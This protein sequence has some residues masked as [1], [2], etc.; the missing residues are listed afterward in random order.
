M[1]RHVASRF[2]RRPSSE[3]IGV[4]ESDFARPQRQDFDA[5]S[6]D[7]ESLHERV[8]GRTSRSDSSELE[9]STAASF[10]TDVVLPTTI[11]ATTSHALL[12]RRPAAAD[13]IDRVIRLALDPGQRFAGRRHDRRCGFDGARHFDR[14]GDR[15]LAEP[16][17]RDRDRPNAAARPSPRPSS[18]SSFRALARALAATPAPRR[19]AVCTRHAVDSRSGRARRGAIDPPTRRE[20]AR[21]HC[22]ELR[23]S[24]TTVS[25]RAPGTASTK[26][27]TCERSVAG[28]SLTRLGGFSGGIRVEVRTL[29]AMGGSPKRRL[30]RP[31]RIP[32]KRGARL[33][34]TRRPDST[35]CPP[36]NDVEC[37][38]RGAA[39]RICKVRFPASDSHL[40]IL[41]ARTVGSARRRSTQASLQAGRNSAHL[42]SHR[43]PL[44]ISVARTPASR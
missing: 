12:R 15:E 28:G 7:V 27:S 32:A 22:R 23:P 34:R 2:V 38:R 41:R 43:A 18:Y 10:D 35:S 24:A 9:C 1:S 33:A 39:T 17:E 14:N 3:P 21:G 16:L 4:R 37:S 40:A 13:S 44:V 19:C 25:S 42:G 30:G 5:R 29:A 26:R 11:V 8:S 20:R 6:A 36:R 31:V